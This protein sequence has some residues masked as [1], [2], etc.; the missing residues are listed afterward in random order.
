MTRKSA[1]SKDR[2]AADKATATTDPASVAT[3]VGAAETAAQVT[4]PTGA[5]TPATEAAQPAD[6]TVTATIET[7][8][9]IGPG[10][11]I[12]NSG[13]P[14]AASARLEVRAVPKKGF[15]RAGRYWPH[16]GVEVDFD[17]L[18]EDEWIALESEPKIVIGE[19]E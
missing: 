16:E 1:S 8:D 12:G 15:W 5:E 2:K 7:V 10:E 18:T 13:L 19:V 6:P 14:P 9:S 3:A 17:E 11:Q 4:E